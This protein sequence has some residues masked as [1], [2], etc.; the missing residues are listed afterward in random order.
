[1]NFT[2]MQATGNDFILV[3]GDGDRSDFARRTCDRHFGIG[4]D[5][6]ITVTAVGPGVINMRIFNADGSEAEACG[7]GLRCAARYAVAQGLVA[8]GSDELEIV[9]SVGR[10]HVDITYVED[11]VGNLRVSLGKPIFRAADIPVLVDTAD[12]PV[13][14][15]AVTVGERQ[16][17]M[18][19][20]S[21]GNP[22]AIL[23]SDR[24]V[25]EFPLAAVGPLVEH[26]AIF[27][28][29]TNFEVVR[30]LAPDHLEQ[31]TWERGV[32]ETLAC[33]S[34]A[35]AAVVSARLHGLIRDTVTVSLLG[36]DVTVSWDGQ[37][38]VFLSGPAENIFSGSW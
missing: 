35:C 12:E 10:R 21:M 28:R 24:P 38:E 7:N 20:V 6:L 9:T 25:A 22:H 2:K 23:Y 32:G 17:V 33:G 30:R 19:F 37:G 13:Q 14:G 8:A 5:G 31:R 36:G 15:Y 3:T 18:S 16:Y 4:A 11:Q 29:R 26:H 34:G 27:P 1:M